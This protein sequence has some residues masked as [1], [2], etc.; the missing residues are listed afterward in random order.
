MGRRLPEPITRNPGE[1]DEEFF[2]RQAVCKRRLQVFK[3]LYQQYFYWCAMRETGE[4]GDVVS[5]EGTDYYLGDLLT[6]LDTL[7]RQQRRAFELICLRGFTESAATKIVLP[8]S[9]WPTPVQQYA[10]DGLRKMVAAYD[11]KQAGT[12]SPLALRR[13]WRARK[14]ERIVAK[15]KAPVHR[16]NWTSWSEDHSALAEYINKVTE[17]GITPAQVKAV[18]FLRKEWYHSDGQ[19]AVRRRRAEEVAAERA[20]YAYETPEQRSKRIE[21]A[22]VL[23]SQQRVL[24]RAEELMAEV[25]RLRE[26]AGLDPVT[27]EPVSSSAA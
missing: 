2:A 23:K 21:A 6:G 20:K 10:D 16:W 19:Q 25:K 12:W 15:T 14:R 5:I 9:R 27:G 18:S 24:Q 13:K 4:I 26:E 1:T 3:R 7:P 11:A 8:E 22:R 17:L